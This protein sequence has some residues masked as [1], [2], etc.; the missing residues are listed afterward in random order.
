MWFTNNPVNGSFKFSGLV[1]DEKNAIVLKELI[2]SEKRNAW[3][4][5]MEKLVMGTLSEA[6][7][8]FN[9][10]LDDLDEVFIS[11]QW[12]EHNDKEE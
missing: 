11:Q 8:T 12:D 5:A 2:Q 1:M 4:P 6:E 7:I 3:I 10:I 9:N